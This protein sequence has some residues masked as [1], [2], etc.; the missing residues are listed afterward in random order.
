MLPVTA[1]VWVRVAQA[2]GRRQL[3]ATTRLTLCAEPEVD[4]HPLRE[5]VVGALPVGAGV[6]VDDVARAVASGCCDDWLVG[7]LSARLVLAT[8]A[9]VPG[10]RDRQRGDWS[11]CWPPSASPV[12]VPVAVGRKVTL[13]VQLP[14]AAIER[15]RCWSA[16]SHRRR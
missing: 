5:G 13:T 2:R 12:R 1:I 3:R 11:R 7:R 15:R 4:L 16:C 9:P 10:Q 14:P 8:G 6:A